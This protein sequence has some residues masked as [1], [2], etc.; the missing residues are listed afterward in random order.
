MFLIMLANK[1]LSLELR[2]AKTSKAYGKH[3]VL[4]SDCRLLNVWVQK[5]MRSYCRVEIHLVIFLLVLDVRNGEKSLA[6]L[7]NHAT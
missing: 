4:I 2:R 3:Y 7:F 6:R 1:D 5:E